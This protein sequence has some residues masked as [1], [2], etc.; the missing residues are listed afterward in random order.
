[1][2]SFDETDLYR[3]QLRR[4][5][6]GDHLRPPTTPQVI[7]PEGLQT[8]NPCGGP[9]T[10][11]D[12]RPRVLPLRA[13]LFRRALFAQARVCWTYAN[14]AGYGSSRA[15]NQ[16]SRRCRKSGLF[17]L[18]APR[19]PHQR[20]A[21]AALTPNARTSANGRRPQLRL[22]RLAPKEPSWAIFESI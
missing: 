7:S 8:A 20:I 14:F 6:D 18:R 9:V 15:S 1:M 19:L 5:L 3:R 17:L 16:A 10:I 22:R 2:A 4:S 13:L 11:W 21:R 12:A